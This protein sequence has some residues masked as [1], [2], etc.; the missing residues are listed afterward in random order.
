MAFLEIREWR[1]KKPAFGGRVQR[2]AMTGGQGHRRK[3]NHQGRESL[4]GIS[5]PQIS[6]V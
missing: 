2:L 5:S 1:K 6:T 4:G 3:E